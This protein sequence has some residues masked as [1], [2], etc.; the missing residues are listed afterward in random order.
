MIPIVNFDAYSL[1]QTT[2]SEDS[3]NVQ[4]L[5]KEICHAFSSVGF[6]YIQNHGIGGSTIQQFLSTSKQFFDEPVTV[7]KEYTVPKDDYYGWMGFQS[8]SLNPERKG[9][10][11][12]E[13]YNFNPR[14]GEK[15]TPIKVLP[16][17]YD[18]YNN[19]FEQCQELAYRIM[20][21]MCIGMGLDRVYIRNCHQLIGQDG[22]L[23]SLRS[24]YY[25]PV[26]QDVKPGQ[27][28]C[29]EHTDYGTITLLFQD[30]IGGLQVK[31]CNAD[32]KA[33]APILGTVL[34]NLGA[35]MQRWTADKLLATE[36]R[37]IIPEEEIKRKTGRQSVAFFVQPD[38][39]V[40]ITCLD[41]SN[42]YEPIT[43]RD[44]LNMRFHATF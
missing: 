1:D 40:M 17:F 9:G 13:S 35:L 42:K 37:V 44:Y 6:V 26:P 24:L 38:D 18:V 3:P 31:P 4:K 15:G 22:N 21:L 12:K 41:K 10:D 28:R 25:P 8:E 7:K 14:I 39:D 11:L 29:G 2:D 33:A 20:D 32:F 36:H 16:N 23:T 43:A 19:F 30:D 34:V 5:A 27:I